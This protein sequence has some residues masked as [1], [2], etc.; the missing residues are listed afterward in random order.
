MNTDIFLAVEPYLRKE[1]LESGFS[2]DK[3]KQ[4]FGAK[5]SI[6]IW[7]MGH[8]GEI[9]K[10]YLDHA[11]I[12]ICGYVDNNH[13]VG[14]IFPNEVKDEE[15]FVIVASRKYEA[16]ISFQ[17]A[18]LAWSKIQVIYF[19]HILT[20]MVKD[21]WDTTQGDSKKLINIVREEIISYCGDFETWDEA[22]Q[23]CL[24]Y[25]TRNIM[26][27]A[28]NQAE[29]AKTK[30]IENVICNPD[31]WLLLVLHRVLAG[32]GRLN[33]LDVGG[34]LG[35]IY[36]SYRSYLPF[37]RWSIVEQSHFVTYGAEH[38]PEIEFYDNV[39]R[40]FA[41]NSEVNVAIFLS[42]L[43]YIHDPW[44]MLES[45]IKQ[46]IPYIWIER[47]PM[48]D[49]SRNVITIQNVPSNI[50]EGSYPSWIFSK[51]NLLD[52]FNNCGYHPTLFQKSQAEYPVF[53]CGKLSM[54]RIGGVLFERN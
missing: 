9:C 50:Y 39:D 52:Y 29:T 11:G 20:D 38:F 40:C 45:I 37:D 48:Y 28:A 49:I 6:L 25:K 35:D 7:G 51:N 15:C 54:I 27:Y 26:E 16:M 33:V 24:G 41:K 53:E 13:C 14:S 10:L 22:E 46:E 5:K 3:V 18:D 42:S 21:F 44:K 31:E 19:S 30:S 34:A 36:Y 1:L 8:D 2:D 12:N 32:K 4:R 43:Q 23:M 47:I 17:I